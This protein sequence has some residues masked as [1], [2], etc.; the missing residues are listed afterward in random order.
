M[1][2]PK[3]LLFLNQFRISFRI[4]VLSALSVVSAAV[5][6]GAFLF[7]DFTMGQ[8][9]EGQNQHAR[10][11][12]LAQQVENGALQ[13]RRREKDFII[14]RD[15]KYA[16]RYE[17]AVAGVVESLAE[18][19]NMAVAGPVQEEIARLNSGIA[20][21]AEQFQKVVQLN[22]R[23]GF[24]EKSGLQGS[25]RA[26]VHA[27]ETKLKEAQ[28]DAL[29]VKML[30]MR[31]H[32]KDFMLRGAE[33]YIG[34]IDERRQEFDALLA[35]APLPTDFKEEVS[36]LMD[37]YQRGFQAWAETYLLLKKETPLL[38]EIFAR[39]GEDFDRTFAVASEGL[40]AA[41]TS[42]Q[43]TRSLTRSVF[44]TIGLL[45]L[46]S[47]I[48]FGIAIGRSV[49]RP[50]QKITQVMTALAKGDTDQEIP[51]AENKD[52]IGDIVRA[53][54]VF[55]E[56]A[57]ERERLEAQQ[58]EQREAQEKRARSIE[59]MIA[60]FDSAVGNALES[61]TSASS[62]LDDTAKT[63][64]DTA[65]KTSQRSSSAAKAAEAASANVQTVAAASEEL[66]S[67]IAEIGRQ[68]TQ[69]TDVSRQAKDEAGRTSETMRTLADAAEKI[70]AVV[71]LIQDIAEQ[72]NLLALNATI[73]AARAGDAGKGFAVVAGEVKSLAN[74]TAKATEE[75][76]QQ[77][78]AMQSST[79]EAVTAI[80]SV[81]GTI[82]QMAEI[83]TAISSAVEEQGAATH[84]ISKNVQEASTGTSEVT[85]NISQVDAATD[86]TTQAA[87]QVT[88]LASDLS[89]QATKLRGE[90]EGFLNLVK[91]A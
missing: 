21:H 71:N 85:N 24:D 57:I 70:G 8:A 58:S 54:L 10:L 29:T 5:L 83:A 88:T 50:L 53:V 56:N 15:L 40:A 2:T 31:R 7:G 91:A 63:M 4:G 23:L 13:M 46:G 19:A 11:A 84:E 38:S 75:I 26:A 81:N 39:M 76:S 55:K 6:G 74:Q 89:E 12:Q 37:E 80:Q 49:S 78:A 86:E 65:A 64:T 20:E 77:I 67:A 42:L 22:E 59:T 48:A 17:K 61:V 44:L 30:M 66:H 35:N 9:F 18:M 1:F 73:E 43:S 45:V 69:S 32:E 27:V 51:S 36:G 52:E 90:I 3:P 79:G 60:S 28:L 62:Q 16:D 47:A 68:V 25:L 87:N 72:T 14:R 34:R 33:K 41:G 82:E